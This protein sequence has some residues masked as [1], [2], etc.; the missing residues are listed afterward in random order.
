MTSTQR[1]PRTDRA[2]AHERK[3]W[4]AI[5]EAAGVPLLRTYL[6]RPP[7]LIRQLKTLHECQVDVMTRVPVYRWSLKRARIFG[8]DLR[9]HIGSA[10]WGKVSFIGL[11]VD[12]PTCRWLVSVEYVG[13]E[14]PAHIAGNSTAL[15][16]VCMVG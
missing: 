8:E 12:H 13:S 2:L 14:I 1:G 3:V 11:F 15:M 10:E 5:S 16:A 7:S 9:T 4:Q 6:G